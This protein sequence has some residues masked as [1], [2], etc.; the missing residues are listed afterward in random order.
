M[1]SPACDYIVSKLPTW[2][3]PNLI[4]VWGFS[5]ILACLAMTLLLYGNTTEGEYSPLLACFCGVAYFIYTTADNC[6]GKQARKNK[7]GSV[8]GMLFDHGLDATTSILMNV[9]IARIL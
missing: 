6:D 4:T 9:V 3:A 8:M 7:T 1:Q 5:W 2:L